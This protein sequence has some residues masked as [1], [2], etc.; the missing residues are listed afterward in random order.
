MHL[1]ATGRVEG[2]LSSLAQAKSIASKQRVEEKAVF[3]YSKSRKLFHQ[4]PAWIK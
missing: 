3:P 4:S 2:N 1:Q